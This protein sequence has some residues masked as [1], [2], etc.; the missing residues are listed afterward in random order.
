MHKYVG[1]MKQY[2]HL[3]GSGRITLADLIAGMKKIPV[4]GPAVKT[5]IEQ[6]KRIE[7]QPAKPSII[8]PKEE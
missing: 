6:K 8:N 7:G 2:K 5:L 1:N 4:I 3:H